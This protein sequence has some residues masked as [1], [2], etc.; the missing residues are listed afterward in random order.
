MEALTADVGA[1]DLVDDIIT[2]EH[3]VVD[4]C[5]RLK[6][7]RAVGVEPRFK[8]WRAHYSGPMPLA[9]WIWSTNAERRH[10]T[11]DQI[12]AIQVDL[13]SWE[14][15]ERARQRQAQ[16]R[17]RGG[18]TAG[19]SRPKADSSPT[20]SSGSYSEPRKPEASDGSSGH[21]NDR[22]GDVR[23][24]LADELGESEYRV[25]QVMDLKKADPERYEEV[26]AGNK[27]LKA[28]VKRA[29]PAINAMKSGGDGKRPSKKKLS[30]RRL[31]QA[32]ASDAK[33]RKITEKVLSRA[34]K[35]VEDLY[36]SLVEAEQRYFAQ[37]LIGFIETL[38]K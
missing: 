36:N 38:R 32:A 13:R 26:K 10:L 6:A 24:Q 34:G 28:A 20:N 7:C 30:R 15:Q 8:D 3:Q 21:Q 14:L 23:A 25:Q 4:G 31:N 22:P 9:R 19:R 17:Q 11:R 27:T 5:H 2:F 35:F 1:N 37:E 16:G 33:R 18:E 12:L 29:K